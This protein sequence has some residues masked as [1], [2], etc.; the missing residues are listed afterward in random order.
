MNR[1]SKLIVAGLGIVGCVAAGTGIAIAGGNDDDATDTPIR[2]VDLERAS[3]AALAHTGEGRVTGKEVAIK[4]QYPGVGDAVESDM[5][6]L[7][8]LSP[9]LRRL[10]PGLD[11]KDLLSELSERVIEECD[12]ELEAANHRRIARFWRGHPFVRV[13]AVDTSLSRRRV[14]S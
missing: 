1:T 4:I 10:M 11:V 9:L 14:R 6:N 8:M 2:G 13:P 3:A 5:R 12:Y 7:R